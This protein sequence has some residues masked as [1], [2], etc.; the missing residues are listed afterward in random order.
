MQSQPPES[1]APLPSDVIDRIGGT[2]A[3]AGLCFVSPQAV[4]QWRTQ[5]IPRARLQFL[6]LAR[7]DAFE[8]ANLPKGDLPAL[9]VDEAQPEPIRERRLSGPRRDADLRDEDQPC[10]AGAMRAA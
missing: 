10:A 7:P 2:V 1:S 8:Q 5:G 9:P 3:T 4:T 6:R